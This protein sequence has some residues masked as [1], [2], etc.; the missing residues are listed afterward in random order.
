MAKGTSIGDTTGRVS[1]A[2]YPVRLTHADC[3]MLCGPA[4][5]SPEPIDPELFD[6][7]NP[8]GQVLAGS[9]PVHD[10]YLTPPRRE[11]PSK[12]NPDDQADHAQPVHLLAWD[13]LSG[14]LFFASGKP[15]VS[16]R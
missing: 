3:P 11:A 8:P 14:V 16:C 7:H 13:L 6:D 15:P 9:M 5:Y 1:G 2:C 4:F 12:G 10:V